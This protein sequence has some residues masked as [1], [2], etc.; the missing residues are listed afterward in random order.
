L[1]GLG[2]ALVPTLL[3]HERVLDL[4]EDPADAIERSRIPGLR[5]IARHYAERQ[6]QRRR[7]LIRE[8]GRPTISVVMAAHN[9]A[10]TIERAL[11]SVLAQTHA[12][13]E[14]IVVDDASSDETRERVETLIE[15]DRRLRLVC[16]ASQ[17]GAAMTR[18][19]GLS[20]ATGS[21]LSFHDA[22]DESHPEKLER[23]LAAL[24][25]HPEAVICVCNFR[26]TFPDGRRA[27][28]NGRRFAKNLV[29]MLFPRDPVL[30]Q[31]GY[32][33]DLPVGE[34]AEY[35]ERIRTVFG[36]EREIH[37]FQTLY[38]AQFDEGSL[39]FADAETRVSGSRVD[40][41]RSADA[42]RVQ[43]EIAERM[44]RIGEGA[45]SPFVAFE[46]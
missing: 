28:V 4:L 32:M 18:N 45:I 9:A 11:A 46:G 7:E 26:R 14:L 5:S 30:R 31:L 35:Y 34:D 22:D 42:A 13:I 3:E 19:V 10:D 6:G 39:L 44:D 17:R 43:E 25:A 16:N 36:P 20:H 2:N 12:E 23:Q 21:Y 24:L 41:E 40:F 37:I 33:L 29:S 15:S 38:R 8:A 27:I 1:R